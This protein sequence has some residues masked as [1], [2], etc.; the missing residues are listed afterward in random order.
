MPSPD[1]FAD[2]PAMPEPPAATAAAPTQP[3][4]HRM[5]MGASALAATVGLILTFLSIRGAASPT[6]ASAA[7]AHTA[8]APARPPVSAPPRELPA[9]KSTTAPK[10][11]RMTAGRWV[12]ERRNTVAFEIEAVDRI[13]V[14]TRTV[15][16]VLVVRC[17]GGR[18]ES[19]VFTQ[20]AARM[21]A[22]D[23]DHTVRVAFD[24][25]AAATERWPDS[26]DHDALFAPDGAAFIRR[27]AGSRTLGFGF[28]PHNAKPATAQFEVSGIGELLE[29]SARQC[30]WKQ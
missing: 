14:W 16:P 17:E 5:V 11:N 6:P 30:G 23:G 10:W 13:P 28:E 3:R 8:P 18:A 26:D 4:M 7:A 2:P 9:H 29:G 22:Q 12:G 21:E 24:D 20:S 27:L 25:G 1:T 15:T 19:F